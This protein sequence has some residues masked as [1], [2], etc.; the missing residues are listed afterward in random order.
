VFSPDGKV[1]ATGGADQVIRLWDAGTG[2]PRG[3]LFGHHSQL[4]SL[5]F[6][7]DGKRLLSVSDREDG[8]VRVWDLASGKRLWSAFEKQ[9]RISAAAFA[10]DGRTVAVAND[11]ASIVLLDADT[12]KERLSVRGHPGTLRGLAFSPQGDYLVVHSNVG[13]VEVWEV[14]KGALAFEVTTNPQAEEVREAMFSADGRVLWV[15]GLRRVPG[16]GAAIATAEVRQFDVASG[17]LLAAQ[18]YR[19]E[20]TEVC[21]A[22]VSPDGKTAAATCWDRSVHLWDVATGKWILTAQG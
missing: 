18:H 15:S 1:L 2:R 17:K 22:A 13:P 12:G 4:L 20:R 3:T 7:P 14:A 8:C 6:S 11:T 10:P 16:H 9:W 21:S 19:P 5:A